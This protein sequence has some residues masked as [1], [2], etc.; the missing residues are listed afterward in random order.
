MRCYS[1]GCALCGLHFCNPQTDGR[2]V[3]GG[4]W[5]TSLQHVNKGMVR[6][7][8]GCV[9]LWGYRIKAEHHVVLRFGLFIACLLKRV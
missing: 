2:V 6:Y 8:V 5:V 4:V 7:D 1:G 3:G 9:R